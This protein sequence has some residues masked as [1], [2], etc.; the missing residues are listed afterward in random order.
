MSVQIRALIIT[1]AAA[2][3]FGV[4]LMVSW[5]PPAPGGAAALEGLKVQIIRCEL[6]AQE[7][8]AIIKVRL[9]LRND[10]TMPLRIGPG[11]FWML[12]AEGVPYLDRHAADHPDK[13]PL[14]LA[15]DQTGPE[16]E[17]KF[18]LAPTL[19][20]RSLVLLIGEAPAGKVAGSPPPSQGIRVPLKEDG[21][22]KGPFVEGEWKT[23]VGTRWR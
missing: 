22:P 5:T 18:A 10:G 21:A 19:L 2:L 6:G 17:L 23:F 8:E 16:M 4:V 3:L 13:A 20:A 14:K 7:M 11:S 9:R 12:D 15:P 1:A